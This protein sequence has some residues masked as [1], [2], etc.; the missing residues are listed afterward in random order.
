MELL[1]RGHTVLGASRKPPSRLKGYEGY[2]RA[3]VNLMDADEL[4]RLFSAGTDAIVCACGPPLERMSGVY[5]ASGEARD[6][7]KTVLLSSSHW[8][9]IIVFGKQ[10]CDQEDFPYKHW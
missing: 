10:L 9:P 3:V 4:V 7:I 1:S 5:L 2:S 8:G 6:K